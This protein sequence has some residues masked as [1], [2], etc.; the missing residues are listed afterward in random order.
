MPWVPLLIG[1][2]L[3]LYVGG[4][5]DDAAEDLGGGGDGSLLPGSGLVRL[6]VTGLA[7]YGGYQVWRRVR[8]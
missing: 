5:L 8:P 1:A 7:L 6:A 4:Q 2:G 3:G